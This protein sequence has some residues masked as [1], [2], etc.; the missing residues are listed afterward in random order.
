MG[1]CLSVPPEPVPGD[2]AI[3]D[4]LRPG[5]TARPAYGP[6]DRAAAVGSVRRT[7]RGGASPFPQTAAS[8]APAPA[9]SVDTLSDDDLLELIPNAGPSNVETVCSEVVSRSLQ[10]A[11]PAL[12]ALWRRFSGFGIEKPLREQL[13]V[14]DTLE[15]LGGADARSALRRIVLCKGLPASLLPAALQAAASSGLALP[16]PFVDPLLDHEDAAVRGAAFALAASA[17]VPADRLHASLFARSA[18]DR[19]AAAVA[20]G[21]RGDSRARQP[22]F[23][24]LERSPSTEIIEAVATVWDDDAIVRLGRCAPA[25]IRGSPAPSSTPCATSGA[26]ARKSSRGMWKPTPGVRRSAGS[27]AC[28][29][30]RAR[31][32]SG[33]PSRTP[34]W[35]DPP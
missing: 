5:A 31:Q 28:G 9:P 22:L 27:D 15:R 19:R 16:A 33:V 2:E 10:A 7:R 34:V 21:L 18:A 35:S 20:L 1:R 24:E 25:A 26:R 3:G 4:R 13:A 8:S 17:N 6:G 14:V 12:E 32:A 30:P 29:R 11:V 23:D